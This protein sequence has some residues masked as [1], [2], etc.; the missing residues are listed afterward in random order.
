MAD[1]IDARHIE[2][3]AYAENL[4]LVTSRD[5]EMDTGVTDFEALRLKIGAEL[6]ATDCAVILSGVFPREDLIFVLL[7]PLKI[8][9]LQTFLWVKI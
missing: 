3:S 1:A 2:L 4:G 5:V 8:L 7:F 9:V 6:D